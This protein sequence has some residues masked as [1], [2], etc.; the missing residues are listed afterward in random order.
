MIKISNK[1]VDMGEVH[2]FSDD[3]QHISADIN[4]QLAKVIKSVET[5]DGMTSFSGKTAKDAKRYF[6]ELHVTVLTA[7]QGL[8]EDLEAN[9]KQHIKTFESNVDESENTIITSHYLQEV[10]E[11]IEEV[12]KKLTNEDEKIYDIITEVSDIS[13][14]KSPDFSDVNEWSKKATKATKELEEDISSFT[15]TGNETDVQEIMQRIETVMNQA[16]SSVG[17]TRFEGFKGISSIDALGEL[18]DYNEKNEINIILNIFSKMGE[19]ERINAEML[20]AENPKMLLT[21]LNEHY[22]DLLHTFGKRNLNEDIVNSDLYL[23]LLQKVSPVYNAYNKLVNILSE[24]GPVAIAFNMKNFLPRIFQDKEI[25]SADIEEIKATDEYQNLAASNQMTAEEEAQLKQYLQNINP[26]DRNSPYAP[27]NVEPPDYGPITFWD[28]RELIVSNKGVRPDGLAMPAT[29]TLS[30]MYA[31]TIED[32][33]VFVDPNTNLD[34]KVIV[35]LFMIPTP[36]N[37]GKPFLKQADD[38]GGS[39][40]AGR[41]GMNKKDN[42]SLDSKSTVKSVSNM[43]EFFDMEFGKTI[44]NSLSK[45]KVRYDG[46]SIY[47]IEK[48]IDNQYL[49]KGYGVYLDGLHKDHLEVIDKRGNVKYVL[50]LDGTLNLDK[51]KKIYGRVVNEWK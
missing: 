51:T 4:S 45:S 24:N 37:F 10:R 18:T 21:Y 6:N 39:A 35:A 1:K 9:V 28:K 5:I 16:N 34:E 3:L 32:A 15:S 42:N 33:V 43:N 25:R 17:K 23:D 40:N 2:A 41:K 7:F 11:D 30:L 12:F 44:S 36:A 13:S 22:S 14:A 47:K 48:K 8:F 46:Q 50:N 20:A 29:K 26:E 49:K 38:L 27:E 19:N 31:L